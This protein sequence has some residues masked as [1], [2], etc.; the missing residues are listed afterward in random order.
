MLT[1]VEKIFFVAALA[2]SLYFAGVGFY[3][4]YRAVLRGTGEKPTFGYMLSRLWH[5]AYTW[6]TTRPIW[7]TRGLSSL[8]H[9]MISLGFIFYFLVNFGD[10]LEGMLPVTF[11]GQNI[12]G[13]IY[14][15]LA[16]IATM[17]VLIS[18]I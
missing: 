16:D 11:L 2:A 9:M 8:F 17:S 6:I 13:D 12:V 10:V 7:K 18:V 5:A 1:L 4:V 15:L 3:K 14:R